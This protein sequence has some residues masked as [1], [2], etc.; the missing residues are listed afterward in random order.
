MRAYLPFTVFTGGGMHSFATEITKKML[1]DT[2]TID[3]KT[4]N[5]LIFRMEIFVGK[6]KTLCERLGDGK[7]KKWY[8]NQDLCRKLNICPCTLQTLRTNGTL[9]Y[10]Q[11]NRKI[12]YRPEDVDALVINPMKGKSDK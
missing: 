6:V 7:L 9:P 2:V 4:F 1:M 10:I 12:F 3:E 5:E 8:D 11:I